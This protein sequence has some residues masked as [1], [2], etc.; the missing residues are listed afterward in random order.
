[1]TL[2]GNVGTQETYTRPEVRGVFQFASHLQRQARAQRLQARSPD[3]VS[4]I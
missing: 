1:M 3:R 4:P 2:Y